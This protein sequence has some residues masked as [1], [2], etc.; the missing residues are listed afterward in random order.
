MANSNPC[1]SVIT[2][3]HQESRTRKSILSFESYKRE[4]EE[5]E[6]TFLSDQSHLLP[7][8]ILFTPSEACCSTFWCQV[9]I[10]VSRLEV[11][12]RIKKKWK[13]AMV[14]IGVQMRF[15]LFSAICSSHLSSFHP[16]VNSHLAR[17]NRES[18]L[19]EQGERKRTSK[20]LLISNII[21][22]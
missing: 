8:K 7:I 13:R 9:L 14:S 10:S 15:L 20:T 21:N 11:G 6:L 18:N 22:H 12:S 4:S 17:L 3:Q 19:G 1:S 16:E 2:Y 5:R